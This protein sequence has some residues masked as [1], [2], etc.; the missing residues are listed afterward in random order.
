MIIHQLELQGKTM[1]YHICVIIGHW[2]VGLCAEKVSIQFWYLLVEEL[3][4]NSE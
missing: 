1:G 2:P 4:G 3:L